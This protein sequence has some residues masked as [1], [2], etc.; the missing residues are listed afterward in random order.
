MNRPRE[1]L[2]ANVDIVS[3]DEGIS[4]GV[5]AEKTVAGSE[6]IE[7]KDGS[8]STSKVTTVS[9]ALEHTAT[10]TD[11]PKKKRKKADS[12]NVEPNNVDYGYNVPFDPAYYN[13]FISGYSWVTEPYMYGS[14]GMPY[15]GYPM[16]PYGVN[17]FNGMPPQAPAMPGYPASYQRYV[18][19]YPVSG[20]P[21]SIAMLTVHVADFSRPETQPTHHRGTEAVVSHSRQGKRPKDTRVQPQSHGSKSRNRTR[22]SSERRDHGRSD[23][24]SDDYHEDQS[25]RKRMRDS[26]TMYGD[27]HGGR[28]SRQ[29]Q[30]YD[31]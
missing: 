3:K 22:S 31:S 24:S 23:R 14:M 8:G 12:T 30:E 4:T 5:S 17:S 9:G 1:K 25:S 7:V 26:S 28:R 10:R 29:F 19:S 27:K 13:P 6:V 15:G 11:Q 16:G 2:A 18:L 21:L 20:V